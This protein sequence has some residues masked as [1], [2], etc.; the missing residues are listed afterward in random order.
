[1]K[2]YD[3][4]V[5]GEI[6]L[7]HV[8]T[9]FAKWPQPGEE[10]FT[11][12]Y[13][14][15]LGGGAAITACALGRL[16]R[17]VLLVGVVGRH[18]MAW[19]AERLAQF[20]VESTGL[21][22]GDGGT[23]VTV[24]IS[25]RLERS[26]FTYVGVNSQLEE[27]WAAATMLRSV[28]QARH[29]HLAFPVGARLATALLDR[30]REAGC[31][32]SL[33]VGHQP[34]WLLGPAN[35]NTCARLDYLLPNEREARILAGG[36]AYDYLRFTEANGWP[37]GVVKMGAQGALMRQPTGT[38]RVAA[39]EV[40]AVDTTGAGDA[41]DAGFIDGLLDHEIGEECLRRGCI[42]GSLSTRVAG[43]LSGLP[44]RHD[45]ARCYEETYG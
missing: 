17:S 22:S 8:F 7:D 40:E 6:Y 23:G 28:S 11:K 15:E 34:E 4:A 12:E 41:F 10:V 31:T 25:G 35:Q 3:V 1:M 44:G 14:Q 39:S 37:S 26:F 9:G 16:G 29:V 27:S 30:G 13:V 36:D 5:I 24:S 2:T 42:C 20:G 18:Q 43:A 38:L 21:L 45:F 33:D 19:V 32:V